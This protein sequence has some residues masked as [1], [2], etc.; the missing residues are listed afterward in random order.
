MRNITISV[1]DRLLEAGREYARKHNM[2]LNAL[3]RKLL[4]QTVLPSSRN[5]LDECFQMMDRAGVK[6][7][8]RTW[9]REE[10]Y[11]VEDLH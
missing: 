2:S 9:R 3:I 11:D 1:D 4:A 10:L 5:W 7:G 8:G 6:L